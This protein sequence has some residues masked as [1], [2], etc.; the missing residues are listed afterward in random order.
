[1][2]GRNL[3]YHAW[4]RKAACN[5][6]PFKFNWLGS[7]EVTN[8]VCVAADRAPV[9]KA[10]DLYEREL[11]VGGSGAGSRHQH[12][13]GAARPPARHEVSS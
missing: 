10:E 3:P 9:K 1:M 13:A 11:L 4:C 6:I 5:T 12:D 7:P 2:I 8:R